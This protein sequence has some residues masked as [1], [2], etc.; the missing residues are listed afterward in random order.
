MHP[1]KYQHWANM[2]TNGIYKIKGKRN[3][4]NNPHTP[5]LLDSL[6]TDNFVRNLNKG[7]ASLFSVTHFITCD[8]VS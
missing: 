3:P 5:Q 6:S 8:I 1:W 7:I 2:A 4:Y